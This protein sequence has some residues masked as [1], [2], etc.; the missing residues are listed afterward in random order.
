MATMTMDTPIYRDAPEVR[1]KRE[2]QY[3]GI[4]LHEAGV[5]PAKVPEWQIPFALMAPY[6][7]RG[8]TQEDIRHWMDTCDPEIKPSWDEVTCFQ[9][10]ARGALTAR[11]GLGLQV[12]I[13]GGAAFLA[14]F[15]LTRRRR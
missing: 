9:A 4:L 6:E 10:R 1:A 8:Y 12:A 11:P 2:Y 5:D 7:R 3:L 15:V 13:A 14:A